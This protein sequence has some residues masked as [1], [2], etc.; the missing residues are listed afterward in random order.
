M[1]TMSN[2]CEDAEKKRKT[3]DNTIWVGFDSV[4]PAVILTPILQLPDEFWEL[5]KLASRILAGMT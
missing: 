4:R 1:A 5:V 3:A 2:V